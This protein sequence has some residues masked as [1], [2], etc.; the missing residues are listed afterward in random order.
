MLKFA[1]SVNNPKY[2]LVDQKPLRVST[3]H[4]VDENSNL[5]KPSVNLKQNSGKM[6]SFVETKKG[7]KN[8]RKSPQNLSSDLRK[9][10]PN[11]GY[12]ASQVNSI[13]NSD[14]LMPKSKCSGNDLNSRVNKVKSVSC[15]SDNSISI[16]SGT[17]N[18]STSRVE[19]VHFDNSDEIRIKM[20]EECTFSSNVNPKTDVELCFS[21]SDVEISEDDLD[22]DGDFELSSLSNDDS[23]TEDLIR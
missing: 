12:V 13:N 19:I 5:E 18:D 17:L 6:N 20:D 4:K 21:N 3:Q 10:D 14:S 22:G 11:K 16:E 8:L 9:H 1:I 15:V 7:Y 23:E 2:S